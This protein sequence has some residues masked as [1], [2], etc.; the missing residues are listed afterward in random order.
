MEGLFYIIIGL[1]I[2]SP[3]VVVIHEL[4]HAVFALALQKGGVKIFLGSF[5]DENEVFRFR[6]GRLIVFL[7]KKFLYIGSGS[8]SL[9]NYKGFSI[10]RHI[11]FALGGPLANVLSAVAGGILW[12]YADSP[13]NYL[14]LAFV[15]VSAR[16]AFNNLMPDL[17]TK[18]FFSDTGMSLI[19]DG[20]QIKMYRAMKKMPNPFL[21]AWYDYEN[22]EFESA[23]EK[24][25]LVCE[26]IPKELFP[27]NFLY[28]S[29]SKLGEW[30][31]ASEFLERFDKEDGL[32]SDE[33]LCLCY[34]LMA[35]ERYSDSLAHYQKVLKDDPRNVMAWNNKGYAL[36]CIHEYEMA[37]KHLDRALRL[38]P[39]FPYA[40]NNRGQA[41]L[42]LGDL[43]GGRQDVEESMKLD[44]ENGFAYR[45]LGIYYF[46]KEDYAQALE[47]FRKCEEKD[48]EA[49]LLK[50][51]I[52]KTEAKLAEV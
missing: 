11:L 5:N 4:G 41:K 26:K 2:F 13:Y 10:N 23:A 24:F 40:M 3:I 28:A 29:Y 9:E 18:S 35:Q 7:S 20:Q 37:L 38:S 45:N 46:L 51:Y 42:M 6:L 39:K 25:R 1:V 16:T 27:I 36:L 14:L 34:S 50:D 19:P 48:P 31:K 12:F 49:D 22:E 8:V 30:E 21:D 43:E 33:R 44:P 15:F 32:G 47:H 17:E 52:E